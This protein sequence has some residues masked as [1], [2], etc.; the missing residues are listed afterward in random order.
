MTRDIVIY[1]DLDGS[2]LDHH[3]YSHAAADAL[4]DELRAAAIPV[5]PVTSKTR[6]ELLVI[7][8]TLR[9]NAPF[10]GENGALI[11][12][13]VNDFS[14]QPEGTECQG[15][16]WIKTFTQPRAHWLEIIH[17]IKGD[18][19]DEMQLFSELTGEEIQQLTGLDAESATRAAA[20][21]FGEPIHWIGSEPRKAQFITALEQQG[22]NVLQGGRFLHISGSCDKGTALQWLNTEFGKQ[23]GNTPPF[24][25]AIGDSDN[26]RAML[27]IADYALIIR[28]P[29]HPYPALTRTDAILHSTAYGPAGWSEGIRKILDKKGFYHG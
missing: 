18:F 28:S 22:V 1:T 11:C 16:L 8:E 25:I 17:R 9:S 5:V 4:L 26:D 7:R 15:D 12:I 10:I 20:R 19:A 14:A 21:E 29:D 3:S 13:P 24:S 27:E 6:Q 23:Q 2:L